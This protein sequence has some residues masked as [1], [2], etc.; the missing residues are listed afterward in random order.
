MRHDDAVEFAGM[1]GRDLST[2]R[3]PILREHVLTKDRERL[4]RV[5][6]S[7]SCYITMLRLVS[8]NQFIGRFGMYIDRIVSCHTADRS[9]C[10]QDQYV[11]HPNIPH[12]F[13]S[14]PNNC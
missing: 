12:L 6:T 5:K 10:K 9:T 3:Q 2:E 7:L 11:L 8:A 14:C 13:S 4:K 1:P